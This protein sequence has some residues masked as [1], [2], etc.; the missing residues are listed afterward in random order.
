MQPDKPYANPS[1]F[2]EVDF[3]WYFKGLRQRYF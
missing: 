3:K 2:S 1:P